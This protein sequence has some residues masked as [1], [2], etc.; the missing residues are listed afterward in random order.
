MRKLTLMF[1]FRIS[2]LKLTCMWHH[3]ISIKFSQRPRDIQWKLNTLRLIVSGSSLAFKTD[4]V[5]RPNHCF[6]WQPSG[7]IQVSRMN[8]WERAHA[9]IILI[10]V[11]L[12]HEI[13]RPYNHVIITEFAPRALMRSDCRR[14]ETVHNISWQR[15][16]LAYCNHVLDLPSAF[17]PVIKS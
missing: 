3:N 13:T 11:T 4:L 6:Q 7:L 17:S 14:N 12:H 10:H 16:I 8:W 1:S 9:Q 2:E 5:T 15:R